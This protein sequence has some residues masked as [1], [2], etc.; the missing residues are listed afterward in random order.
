MSELASVTC[1]PINASFAIAECW[2][3]LRD[4]GNWHSRSG[5]NQWPGPRK[6][7]LDMA[8]MVLPGKSMLSWFHIIV[9]KI[10][11]QCLKIVANKHNVLKFRSD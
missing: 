8:E 4:M 9:I 7:G 11:K 10:Y 6:E 3:A 2:V 5:F 1:E